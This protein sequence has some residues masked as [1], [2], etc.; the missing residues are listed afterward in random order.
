MKS[1]TVIIIE[2]HKLIRE[3]WAGFLSDIKTVKVIGESGEFEEGLELIKSLRPDF[4]L[5]DINL[6]NSN[7]SEMIPLI[8]KSSPGTNIIMVT[9]H[10]QNAVVKKMFSLGAKG[11]IT[12]NSAGSEILKAIKEIQQGNSYICDEIK[13]QRRIEN[14]DDVPGIEL[15][16]FR[17]LDIIKLIKQGLQSKEIAEKLFISPR[18]VE[19]HRANILKKLHL[20][21]TVALLTFLNISDLD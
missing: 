1:V 2:D 21:N 7:G 3:M 6:N 12:K 11:Y 17:E 5:L 8:R 13:N 9:M 20:K 15:L 14:K 18:T 16:S 4:V 19:T 10:T